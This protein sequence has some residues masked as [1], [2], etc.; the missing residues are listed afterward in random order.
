MG[1]EG[2]SSSSEGGKRADLDRAVRAQPLPGQQQLPRRG[3]GRLCPEDSSPVPGG[4][5][6]QTAGFPWLWLQVR[7]C[8]GSRGTGGDSPFSCYDDP[9]PRQVLSSAWQLQAQLG[10]GE[11]RRRPGPGTRAEAALRSAIVSP[12]GHVPAS[13]WL[14]VC[15]VRGAGG[16]GPASSRAI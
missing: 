2:G 14:R 8:S 12:R 11:D 4:W 13:P 16:P 9:G 5:W 15:R 10:P 7:S 1:S 6:G 3:T